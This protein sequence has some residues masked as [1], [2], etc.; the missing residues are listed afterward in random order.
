MALEALG[1]DRGAGIHIRSPLDEPARHVDVVELERQV[2]ERAA[3]YGRRGIRIS[4]RAVAI[5]EDLAVS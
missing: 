4:R 5:E 3:G 2:Q 1:V